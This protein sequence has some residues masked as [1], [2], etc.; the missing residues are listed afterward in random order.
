MVKSHSGRYICGR[1]QQNRMAT[2]PYFGKYLIPYFNGMQ[3]ILKRKYDIHV[4]KHTCGRGRRLAKDDIDGKHE[5][6][7]KFLEHYTEEFKV[8]NSRF[9]TFITWVD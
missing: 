4:P 2:T 8:K 5:E 1:P 7:Y 9:T 3:E 6:E